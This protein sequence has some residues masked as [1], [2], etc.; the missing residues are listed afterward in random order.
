MDNAFLGQLVES[1]MELFFFQRIGVS[2]DA[3]ELGAKLG[4][5][6]KW[7]TSPSV[8]VSP[9]AKVPVSWKPT[10]SP[11]HASSIISLFWAMKAVGFA[12]RKLFPVRT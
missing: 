9:I 4:I 2:D 11:G 6:V 12:L 10:I 3:E 7:R 1:L 8:I 5:P